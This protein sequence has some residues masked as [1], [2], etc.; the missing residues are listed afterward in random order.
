MSSSGIT[1]SNS[2]PLI[3]RTALQPGAETSTLNNNNT[4][5][6]GLYDYPVSSNRVLI[7]STNGILAPSDHPYVSSIQVSSIT[8]STLL[9]R[10]G[11]AGGAGE[12]LHT[13]GSTAYWGPSG[14]GTGYWSETGINI[15]NNNPGNV[16]VNNTNPQYN[17]DVGGNANIAST[18]LV[19][20]ISSA[21]VI[22]VFASSFLNI[23]SFR[24][25]VVA[26]TLWYGSQN[27][28]DPTTFKIELYGSNLDIYRSSVNGNDATFL[29]N[30]GG[31]QL[32]LGTNNPI[33]YV[34]GTFNGNNNVG[35]GNSNPSWP[36]DVINTIHIRAGANDQSLKAQ[37][38]RAAST[39]GGDI[40]TQDYIVTSDTTGFGSGGW[41]D[42]R[43][44]Y[45]LYD[46]VGST[47]QQT[48][49]ILLSTNA[50][51]GVGQSI[52]DIHF[53]QNAY[54]DKKLG[55]GT[56]APQATLDVNGNAKSLQIVTSSITGDLT[57]VVWPNYYGK[58]T[59][60]SSFSNSVTF[61][62]SGGPEGSVLVLKNTD[63]T[64]A[65]TITNAFSGGGTIPSNSAASYIFTSTFTGGTWVW[66]AL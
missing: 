11:G 48:W 41:Q 63:L 52:G 47:I 53:Y 26:S 59:F 24:T 19:S 35:I 2:G 57:T 60:I 31:G 12:V 50:N 1:A 6:L 61:P 55:V 46:G 23:S 16:G 10:D 66:V 15:W 21:N 9:D 29:Q 38:I 40:Y 54:I 22:N 33:V 32:V 5:L 65:I 51:P 8:L 25:N 58:Y 3:I 42:A 7:T 39:G 4:Y 62:A 27:P 13:D 17:L 37:F 34:N 30:T 28:T 56:A 64:N 44:V 14:A 49:G 36:L 18:L 43:Y 45:N 20:T